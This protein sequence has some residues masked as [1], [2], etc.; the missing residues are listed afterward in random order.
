MVLLLEKKKGG[1]DLAAAPPIDYDGGYS[2]FL[3]KKML[4]KMIPKSCF[5]CGQPILVYKPSP[6]SRWVKKEP[7]GI[8]EHHCYKKRER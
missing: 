6:N 1:S 4:G 2:K 5:D 7:D 8:T 3:A